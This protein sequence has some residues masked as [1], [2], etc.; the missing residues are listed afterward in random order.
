MLPSI[1]GNGIRIV[2]S[3]G[4]VSIS[5]EMIHDTRVIRLD[6]RPEN[7]DD[8]DQYMG[9]SRGHWEGDTLVV[10]ATHFTGLTGVG[11]RGP[12]SDALKLTERYTRVDPDMVEY[13]VTVDDPV[14]FEA[15]FT[16]RVMFTSQPG[17]ETYEYSCHE[18][19]GAVG[20][21]LSGERAYEK[22][23]AEAIARGET[24]PPRANGMNIYRAPGEE[25]EIFD[26][27][28]GE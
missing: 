10:E 23:V 12:H 9:L 4:S 8:I 7:S 28:A 20:N 13:R 18:G 17:Y 26:I 15:P 5:Y 3:P 22:E 25:A 16:Y 14:T 24:P 19:N 27:N 21:S 2:Q 11:A 1:Y 6:G